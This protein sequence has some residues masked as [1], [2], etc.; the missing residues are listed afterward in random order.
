[1]K[2]PT[3]VI[4]ILS[5]LPRSCPDQSNYQE[6]SGSVSAEHEYL[7]IRRRSTKLGMT[8]LDPPPHW[9][10]PRAW[11]DEAQSRDGRAKQTGI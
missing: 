8:R 11:I 5:P 3:L 10:N 1:M 9:P 6:F 2:F 4:P 7:L